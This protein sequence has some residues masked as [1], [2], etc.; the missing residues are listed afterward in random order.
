MGCKRSARILA[1]AV[2]L[3]SVSTAFANLL[4]VIPGFPQL[5]YD[6]TGTTTYTA[7]NQLYKQV[8]SPIAI[9][10]TNASPPRFVNPTGFPPA[11]VVSINILVNGSGGLVGGTP[12]DDI[13]IQGEVDADGNGSIDYSGILLTGEILE[14]GYLD[15]SL[16]PGGTDQYDFRFTPTGGS[17]LAFFAGKDIGVTTSSEHSSFANDFSIDFTGGAKG[18]VG[19]I[20]RINHP[21]DCDI[22]I[23]YESE[24]SGGT[25]TISLNGSGSSDPDGDTLTYNWTSDCPGATF[26]DAHSATPT[27][28]ITTAPG[29]S[30]S[31]Q[32]S[33][34]VSDGTLSSEPCHES[35]NISDSHAPVVDCP[36]DLT[37]QCT[38]STDPSHTGV[39]TAEDAC[40]TPV[41]T[42]SDVVT[43]GDCAQERVI[44]RT[45]T[46]TDGCTNSQSCVQTITVADTQAPTI[47][48][49][50]DV[51]VACGSAT[52]PDATGS[53]TA[54]D[55]CDPAPVVTYS[56][57]SNGNCPMTI[58][59]TWTATDNCGNFVTCVQTITITDTTKPVI[60]CPAAATVQCGGSTAPAATGTATASDGCDPAPV[61][62]YSDSSSGTCPK[63]ITRAW[64]AT[65]AC[66]NSDTCVQTITVTDSTKPVIS[67]PA[68]ATVQCG[69]ST[70]PAA[71][72]TATATDS[73]DPAPVVTYSDSTSGSCPKTISRTWKATDACG[74]YITCVQT[75]TITDTTKPVITCP[76]AATVQC[77]GSTAP[78]A[79]GSATASDSC[80]PAPV[81][82][83]SDSTSGTC[84]KT[85]S[86]TWK[87][88]DACGNYIICVQ[89]ITI[90]DT[91]KPV[92]T[93]PAAATVQC[94]G[95][96]A[97]SATGSATA[98]DSC[99]PAPVVT[100][101]DS[102]SGTCPKIISRTWKAT[103]ACGNSCTCV[104]TITVT[105][106]T[107]PVITCPGNVT[108]QCGSSTAPSATGTATASDSCNPNPTVTYSDSTTGTCPKIISRTWKATDLCGNSC[109]CVQTITVT[110]TTKPVITCPPTATVAC[111]GCTLPS[112]TGTATASDNCGGAVT[113]CYS[114][115]ACTATG[116]GTFKFTRTWTA[117]DACNNQATCTQQINYGCPTGT[118]SGMK[119]FDAN[120][121]GTKETSEQT[122]PNW[123]ITLSG[124]PI[125]TQI[126][127]TNSSGNYSFGSLPPGTYTVTE[128]LPANWQNTTPVSATVTISSTCCSGTVNFGNYC[129]NPPSNGCCSSWWCGSSGQ[130]CLSGQDNGNNANNWRVTLNAMNLKKADGS[131]F[132]LPVTK[133]GSGVFTTN[134]ATAYASFQSWLN[135]ASS[136]N[137][138]YRL[139]GNLAIA[140]LNVCYK[141]VSDNTCVVVPGGV[142]SHGSSPCTPTCIVSYLC[143]TQ[144]CTGGSP[145]LLT[146]TNVSGSNSCGCTA[147]NAMVK[148]CDLR[149]RCKT[150]LGTYNS[151][152][153]SSTQRTYMEC[154]SDILD[155][156]NNNG[157]QPSPNGC[158]C[159]PVCQFMCSS[160][161]TY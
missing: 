68:A 148:I 8:A 54:S 117:K 144:S 10:F 136:T 137:M 131:A 143:V 33:L 64:K 118:I 37:I 91:T 134:F 34:V 109:T 14:F 98:S 87:A 56:D 11:E 29:C 88:T 44:T 121:N 108:V 94:G 46:A 130:S 74:N 84:P 140:T 90:T 85:I 39:A 20:D 103:D 153:S 124:G 73:C 97:P 49:P 160:I 82:T 80:D 155:M 120:A 36:D 4:G 1:I 139:S 38:E 96:T 128:N 15:A 18:A 147:K 112:G 51:A 69:S 3:L 110:D 60:T 72:G 145:A 21:P 122:L 99:D 17:L 32:I 48:C 41:V 101:S 28:T 92:I 23:S 19:P 78:S 129:F 50:G 66:G 13:V 142:K 146:C 5:T 95:A 151:C 6:S 152:T 25:T 24:C 45:W 47:S 158:Q 2:S 132:A 111:N 55:S 61:V 77:G 81:V 26:D 102:T 62:T 141:G 30:V 7:F 115:G 157:N 93:C 104:Q 135:G 89:T 114:D 52:N 107:K 159:G 65:D 123:K 40:S 83:Y 126:K 119:F 116:C 154:C 42:Y 76:A 67:C 16:V 63:T 133:N 75:I 125:P 161:C 58:S 57:S 35:I 12:G 106:T 79:T 9:R 31:C 127:Y 105:D 100:Y 43:P 149:T 22:V 53:A 71:T 156:C 86:R 27:L 150:L 70:A 138:A 59:R 113:I